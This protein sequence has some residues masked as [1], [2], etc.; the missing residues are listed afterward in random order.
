VNDRH[1]H[2]AGDTVLRA[3]GALL[4]DGTRQTD[5]AARYGGEEFSVILPDTNGEGAII[6]A[7]KLRVLVASEAISTDKR[8][9]AIT[10]SVGVTEY[11]PDDGDSGK[12]TIRRVDEALYRA[13]DLG[14]NRVEFAD[15]I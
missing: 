3:I 4:R 12:M 15:G 2:Q 14:R 13:K 10:V 11:H 7:E 9:L 8:K 1:G 6:T 5:I